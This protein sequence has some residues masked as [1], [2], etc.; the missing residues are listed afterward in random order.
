M[1]NKYNNSL[2]ILQQDTTILINKHIHDSSQISTPKEY[3]VV[4]SEQNLFVHT[5]QNNSKEDT[6]Q[7]VVIPEYKKYKFNDNTLVNSFKDTKWFNNTEDKIYYLFDK[8][9]NNT[10]STLVYI[11]GERVNKQ[12]SIKII[13]PKE[14]IV[15]NYDWYIIPVLTGLITLAFIFSSYKKYFSKLYE[16]VFF[17]YVSKKLADD[18]NVSFKRFTFIL[19][20]LFIIS[21]SLIIDQILQKFNIYAPP[22][23]SEYILAL[24]ISIF[25]FVLRIIRYIIFKLSMLFTNQISFL[26]DLYVNS[27]LYNRILGL[28]LLP[29]V[30]LV[31]Y[32][33]NQ[34]ALIFVYL[35]IFI[36]C[37]N[38]IFRIFRT[39]KVF[40][41]NGLS[42]FYFILYLCALEIA[43]LLV[44]WKEV[45]AR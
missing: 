41:D 17:R 40:I 3:R 4:R 42:I 5:T 19:D 35:S 28:I 33:T 30:F 31:I 44:V 45:Q 24:F 14:K 9:A 34:V 25:L 39:I 6:L 1:N 27:L 8:Q 16:S 13:E 11:A 32:S 2:N 7:V 38:Q 15:S 18:K 23:G 22:K 21:F 20:F 37:I 12:K 36:I 43:P 29:L 10:K 26:K